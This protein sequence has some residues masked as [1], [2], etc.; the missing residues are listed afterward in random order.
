MKE[1]IQAATIT[2]VPF[3]EAVMTFARAY[4]ATPHCGAGISPYAAM[5]GGREMRT[6]LPFIENQDDVVDRER[7]YQYKETI[8]QDIRSR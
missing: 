5:H 7:G 1:A 3:R 6:N 4:R 8:I 2:G